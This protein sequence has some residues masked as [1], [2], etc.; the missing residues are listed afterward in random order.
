MELFLKHKMDYLTEHHNKVKYHPMIIKFCLGL[1]ATSP[2]SDD[3]LRL[4]KDGNGV[5]V[6]PSQRT[7]RDYRHYITPQRGFNDG[8]VNELENLTLAP[9]KNLL[10]YHLMK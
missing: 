1:Q 8:I 9:W 10:C 6:L 2:A 3:Q 5:L 7:L 4:N